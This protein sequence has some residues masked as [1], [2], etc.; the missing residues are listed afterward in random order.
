MPRI[1]EISDKFFNRDDTGKTLAEFANELVPSEAV[2]GEVAFNL[3]VIPDYTFNGKSVYNL[4]TDR[5]NGRVYDGLKSLEIMSRMIRGVGTSSMFG[6]DIIA[7]TPNDMKSAQ[8][9]VAVA[10]VNANLGVS[11][12][13]S[14]AKSVGLP[15][16]AAYDRLIS[17]IARKV[18]AGG[19]KVE[20]HLYE[21]IVQV[22]KLVKAALNAKVAR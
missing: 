6:T 5:G 16:V 10:I 11:D 20:E 19:F 3:P 1:K 12:I 7:Y 21:A 13:Y 4:L 8:M 15:E 9:D 18:R 22:R 17:T 2:F 14:Y